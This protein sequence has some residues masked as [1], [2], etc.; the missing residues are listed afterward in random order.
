[1]LSLLST[2]LASSFQ[3]FRLF[4]RPGND[5]RHTG[6]RPFRPEV[7]CLEGRDLLTVSM[8]EYA[9]PTANSG[10]IDITRGPDGNLWFAE[11]SAHQVARITPSGSITEYAVSGDPVDIWAGQGN[12]VW[13]SEFDADLVGNINT[14]TGQVTEYQVPTANA[15]PDGITL[16]ADGNMWFDEYFAGKV[17]RI[18][19]SGQITEYTTGGNPT[20]LALGSDGNVWFTSYNTDQ[21]GSVSTSG[22]VTLYNLPSGSG[23]AGIAA[24]PDGNLWVTQYNS[25]QIAKVT[26]SGS[27]TEYDIPTANSQPWAIN[28]S[29][30]GTLWFA[31]SG[32]DKI[33]EVTTSGQFT[34]Y[35]V[36][37]ANADPRGITP[38]ADGSVWWTEYGGNQ[39]G[40]AFVEAA[41]TISLSVSY[42]TGT[43]VTL[44]GQVTADAPGG[45]TVDFTG[46]VV[47]SVVTNADGTFSGTFQATGLGSVSATTTD[48]HGLVSNTA[49]I[50]LTANAPVITNFAATAEG[51]NIWTFSG[52]VTDQTPAGMVVTFGGLP[53][54]VGQTAIVQANGTFELTVSLQAGEEGTA[55]AQTIDA[56]GLVSNTVGIDIST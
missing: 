37:T 12:L 51:S 18:T 21:V 44:S 3:S 45:L 34:E 43:T 48:A 22:V 55:T 26:T 19:P 10:A 7:E 49:T 15:G 38:A 32:S 16:G 36:P 35:D 56:W 20:D 23:P 54:L 8:A 40:A 30:D 2:A 6:R 47:G 50:V 33:G 46:Q 25:G 31:E 41:P 9:I 24:G 52:T 14:T 53:S 11:E 1:V 4:C 5:A 28:A 39:I 42:L 13:F 17:A 29:P 27:V